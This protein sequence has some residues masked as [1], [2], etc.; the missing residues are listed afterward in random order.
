MTKTTIK[1]GQKPL[2]RDLVAKA[3]WGNCGPRVFAD[4]RRKKPKHKAVYEW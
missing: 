2:A 4:K 3:M 1:M